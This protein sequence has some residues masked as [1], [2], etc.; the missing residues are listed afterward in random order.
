M[1]MNNLTKIHHFDVIIVQSANTYG[2]K[3]ILQT[4]ILLLQDCIRL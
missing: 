2:L 1:T 3:D 4:I